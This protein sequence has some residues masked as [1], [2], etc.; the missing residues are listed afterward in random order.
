MKKVKISIIMFILYMS[1]VYSASYPPQGLNPYYKELSDVLNESLD[2]QGSNAGK[3]KKDLNAS[4]YNLTVTSLLTVIG[5]VNITLNLNVSGEIYLRGQAVQIEANAFN[6]ENNLSKIL[7]NISILRV[8]NISNILKD[9][10]QLLNYSLEYSST[11]YKKGNITADYPNID[12]NVLDEFTQSNMTTILNNGISNIIVDTIQVNKLLITIGNITN[13]NVST[14]NINGSLMPALDNTFDVGNASFR[15][16]NANFSGIVGITTLSLINKITSDLVDLGGVF[17]NYNLINFT[18]N[19]NDRTDRFTL[20]NYSNEYANTGYKKS[21]I[22]T[23]YLNIDTSVLD[24]WILINFT[25]AY[26]NRADRFGLVNYSTEYTSTGYKILNFTD[27]YARSGY[28]KGNLTIDYPN[29]DI[30]STNDLD[31]N[32]LDNNTLLRVGNISNI[33]LNTFQN[34]NW[35]TLYNNEAS[36]RFLNINFTTLYNNILDRF[37]LGNYSTEYASTG[38]KIINFTDEYGRSGYKKGNYSDEYALSGWKIG[39]MTGNN[40]GS[41]LS[42]NTDFILKNGIIANLS[43]AN[44]NITFGN[45]SASGATMFWQRKQCN[46][47]CICDYINT[48]IVSRDCFG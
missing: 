45:G 47:T 4:F 37:G 44:T 19:Y 36:T 39:N 13:A 42:N 3:L 34:S 15:W 43:I 32:A 30:D 2:L 24:E 48:T 17:S 46:S 22:T 11:G 1:F 10:F 25:I 33:L 27:E 14:I 20:L 40:L 35:T 41:A 28:K 31:L 7:D 5:N 6:F 23:D 26:D 29:L 38:Y 21:N 16:K 8:G 12:L 9:T 18:S